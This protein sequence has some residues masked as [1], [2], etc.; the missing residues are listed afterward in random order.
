MLHPTYC[1]LPAS[2][3]LRSLLPPPEEDREAT[4]VL[5]HDWSEEAV[6]KAVEFLYCGAINFPQQDPCLVEE[7]TNLLR[8][9]GVDDSVLERLE[10]VSHS[11][12]LFYY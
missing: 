2:P 11:V 10:V 7:V 3:V 8:N 9:I 4:V 6:N 5:L 12:S 1:L